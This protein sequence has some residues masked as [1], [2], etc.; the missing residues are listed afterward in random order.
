MQLID[1]AVFE[2]ASGE[3]QLLGG[4]VDQQRAFHELA[5]PAFAVKLMWVRNPPTPL[6]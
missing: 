2:N 4:M 6:N 3:R 5:T 1:I